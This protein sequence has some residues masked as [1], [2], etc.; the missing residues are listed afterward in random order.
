MYVM[1]V[2]NMKGNWLTTV[3][4]VIHT[5]FTFVGSLF[6]LCAEPQLNAV[7]LWAL[8]V[9]SESDCKY[10]PFFNVFQS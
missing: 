5:N 9:W 6:C 4:L 3:G 1:Y 8:L 2:C 7:K 10:A